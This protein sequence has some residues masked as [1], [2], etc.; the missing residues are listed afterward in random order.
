[1]TPIM[2]ICGST[3]NCHSV[4][5]Q[6]DS[7]GRIEGRQRDMDANYPCCAPHRVIRLVDAARLEKLEARNAVLERVLVAWK[8]LE[9]DDHDENYKP[10]S[11]GMCDAVGDAAD[12]QASNASVGKAKQAKKEAKNG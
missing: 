10:C 2:L 12:Q 5:F 6:S 8:S 11:C 1:M 4:E 9:W 3:G 7:P